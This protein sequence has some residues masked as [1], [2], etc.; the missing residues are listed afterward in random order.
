MSSLENKKILL[1]V[2]G[3]I[4]V[5][6]SAYLVRALTKEGAEVKVLMTQAAQAF[7]SPLTFSTLSHN[8][9]YTQINDANTWHSHVELGLWADIMLIAPATATTLSKMAAGMADNMVLATYLSAKCPVFIAPAMDL[10]M[11]KHPSTKNNLAT[12]QS[13]GHT[14][15]PVGY[16]ELASGL[17]GDGRMA[18]PDEIIHFLSDHFHVGQDLKGKKV[19]ITA[20]PTHEAIDPV[21]Y[22]GNHS[23]GKMGLSLAA[24]CHKRGAEV[25][26]ILGPVSVE[27]SEEY[28]VVHVQS[29]EEMYEA[30][31]SH[32]GDS[33]ILIMS[34]AVA[35]Y[36]PMQKSKDKIKKQAESTMSIQLRKTIDIA[37]VMGKKKKSG[38]IMIGFALET[39]NEEENALKKLH[40]KNFDFI[41]LNSLQDDGA[42]FSH[43]TNKITIYY[44]NKNKKIFSLKSKNEVAIDIVNELVLI[45]N[46]NQ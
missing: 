35:D 4:A 9:V 30:T 10:D 18:E 31:K 38:Q 5:Y 20:G 21:R 11:W 39:E 13:Y 43:D 24:Q 2:S 29:A 45:L 46:E 33:D 36:T 16:G 34:A 32:A 3:S 44:K 17:I 14:I 19:L 7:V 42:G 28:N 6:K 25:H 15:I 22:I 12:L 1:A 23:T 41:V 40:A 37:E 8:P 27:V 26:V